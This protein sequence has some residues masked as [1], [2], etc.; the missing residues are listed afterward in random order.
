MFSEELPGSACQANP[1]GGV[2]LQYSH[3]L[4]EQLFD[5]YL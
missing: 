4:Q 3:P 2:E 1:R 5:R